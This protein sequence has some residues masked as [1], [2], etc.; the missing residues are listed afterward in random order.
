MQAGLRV[1]GV[2]QGSGFRID[3]SGFMDS[4]SG[5]RA[6]TGLE[7]EV[8]GLRVSCLVCGLQKGLPFGCTRF[9]S[10]G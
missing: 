2:S 4:G 3:V 8:S 5:F 10:R 9:T 1:R 6:Y 7:D